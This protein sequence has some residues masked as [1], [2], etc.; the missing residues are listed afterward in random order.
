M[1]LS[2]EQGTTTYPAMK[3]F[4]ATGDFDKALNGLTFRSNIE[5]TLLLGLRP[6]KTDYLRAIMTLN[7]T[8][9]NLYLH[10]FQ[11]FL[12]NNVVSERLQRFP[13]KPGELNSSRRHRKEWGNPFGA[14]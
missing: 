11:S 13:Q 12:W 5:K 4:L 14:R 6:C 1:L 8:M 3:E 2:G 10:A 9:R 7:K